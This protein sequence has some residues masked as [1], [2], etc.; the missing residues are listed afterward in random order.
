MA[1]RVDRNATERLRLTHG[2]AALG[3]SVAQ[4]RANFVWLPVG[5]QAEA[6][7]AHL[8]GVGIAARCFAREGVRITTG[9]AGDTDAVLDA[10]ARF[11]PN[12]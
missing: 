11:R 9:T 2:I 5:L 8:A 4:S 12:D 10:L 3:L 6:L 1:A 7:N